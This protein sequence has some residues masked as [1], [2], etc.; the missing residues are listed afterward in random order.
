MI[1]VYYSINQDFTTFR[2]LVPW[3]DRW[4]LRWSRT[5]LLLRGYLV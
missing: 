2:S 3:Q 4:H 5:Y 1:S